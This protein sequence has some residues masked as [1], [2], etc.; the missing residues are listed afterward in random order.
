MEAVLCDDTRKFDKK[1]YTFMLI[2]C[3]WKGLAIKKS[4]KH[5]SGKCPVCGSN[6]Y[7]M[8]NGSMGHM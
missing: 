1:E 8:Q 4:N 6:I 3:H 2:P 5:Q 7:V